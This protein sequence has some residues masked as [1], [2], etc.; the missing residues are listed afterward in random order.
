MRVRL[1][2]P[3]HQGWWRRRLPALALAW[4]VVATLSLLP[5][6]FGPA[7]E[8][9]AAAGVTVEGPEIWIPATGTYGAKGQVSV[10]HGKNLTNEVVQVSWSGFTPTVNW[11][12]TP[13][14]T[15]VEFNQQVMYAVRIY[16]CRG[17]DP[18]PTDCYGNTMY[19]GDPALGFEQE[20]RPPGT[21]TPDFPS[22]HRIA[23]TGPDGSGTAGFEVWTSRQ[24]TSLGCDATHPC[25]IVVEP[26]YGGDPLDW[27]N[28]RG[29]AADCSDH[30]MD[31]DFETDNA[32]DIVYTGRSNPNTNHQTGEQCAWTHRA[33]VPLEFAP[34]ADDCKAA[35]ADFTAAGLE[36][37]NRAMQQWRAGLCAGTA[38]ISLQ[39]TSAG[40][41]PQARADFLGGAG[42]DVALT[43]RP[44]RAAAPRPYVYAPLATTGISV[45]FLLDDPVTGAQIR[46]VRLNA[47]L[48]AK[49]L[50]QSYRLGNGD[51][52]SVADNPVCIFA[53]PEFLKLNAEATAAGLHWPACGDATTPVVLGGTTDLAHQVTSWIAADPEAAQFLQGSPDPWGMHV[54]T[55]YMRPK[56]EGYPTEAFQPQDFSG[57]VGATDD[58]SKWK[59]YEWN[60]LL[61]GLG[62]VG[63]NLLQFQSTAL[64]TVADGSG[65][66]P[67]IPP[68]IIGGRTLFGIL[69]AGQATAFAMPEAALRNPAGDFVT[70]SLGSFQAA[71]ADMPVDP[72]TGTQQLPY[73]VS[74]TDFAKDRAAYPLT[75]VQYA[76]VPTAGLPAAKATA[77]SSFLGRVTDQGE[78]QVYGTNPGQ[79]A[80]G[81]LGLTSAQVAQAKAATTHVAAQDSALPGNQTAPPVTGGGTTGGTDSGA[82][83]GTTASGGDTQSGTTSG[84][85]TGTDSTTGGGLGTTD[86]AGA[87]GGTPGAPA[88]AP[89]KA[90]AATPGASPGATPLTAAPVAAGRPAPDRAGTARLLLPVALIAGLVLLVGGPAALVL[91]GTSAGARIVG[92][93][94]TGW[95]RLRRGGS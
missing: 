13:A 59:M 44:D 36:M 75:T 74:G 14:A 11:D 52:P 6:G 61:G 32:T 65:N 67:K 17:T 55:F 42:A 80:P 95:A 33:V 46:N 35:H 93:L 31:M 54:D 82:G 27:L 1:P 81:F 51:L 40:G 41:E 68:Q 28:R 23:V 16:Q 77:L 49:M 72:L 45:V 73:G 87:A 4:A 29:G 5:L 2:D 18:K 62:Q 26:N 34:T 53:D 83:A 48:L 43:A 84:G 92:G 8:A 25:S 79:L 24:S 22:N 71:L 9:R 78:G 76:M 85:G 30:S 56:Y 88:T 50:T 21:T 7:T 60:P 94:R 64:S 20:T 47:R 69:D 3:R 86:T 37:A 10:S 91:G 39:Y 57:V 63:R 15:A 19:G 90:G 70:P 12:G 89:A 58:R 66:H 38:P